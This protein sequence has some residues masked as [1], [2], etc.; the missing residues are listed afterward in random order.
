MVLW[1]STLY[2]GLFDDVPRESIFQGL[3]VC[4]VTRDNRR[5]FRYFS[6]R[7]IAYNYLQSLNP[8]DRCMFEVFLG[9]RQQKAHFDID[10]SAQPDAELKARAVISHVVNSL[11]ELKVSLR[12]IRLYQSSAPDST[13][14]S[15][16]SYHLLVTNYHC[17]NS[18]HAKSLWTYCQN[19]LPEDLKKYL[20]EKV[21]SSIQQFRLLGHT[22]PGQQRHKKLLKQ[23]NHDGMT[24]T[25]DH[26]Y[27]DYEQFLESLVSFVKEDSVLLPQ[28]EETIISSKRKYDYNEIPP[29][30]LEGALELL[31]IHLHVSDHWIFHRTQ[32]TLVLLKRTKPSPCPIC[33]GD[34]EHTGNNP[35]L[36]LSC[37]GTRWKVYYFCRSQR[38]QNRGLFLG[39]IEE[40]IEDTD[41]SEGSQIDL[42]IEEVPEEMIL[43]LDP[44]KIR[45]HFHTSRM[46]H[47]LNL[48]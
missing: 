13:A 38:A 30:V 31:R 25:G 10:V 19:R 14:D 6:D 16:Q 29:A 5:S 32:S 34:E 41:I 42:K 2:N 7:E 37:Q 3:L 15:K 47:A 43:Q 28:P 12:S 9:E 24:V 44:E 45:Q 33:Q 35:F 4:Q 22:K 17:L 36:A 40:N 46:G 48:S 1:Y 39:E 26:P 11:I 8:S 20:D 23:W 21:Y 27:S 18:T